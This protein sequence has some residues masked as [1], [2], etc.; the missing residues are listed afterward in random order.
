MLTQ[1][2][3]RHQQFGIGSLTKALDADVAC[4]VVNH[5]GGRNAL[6]RDVSA[7]DNKRLWLFVAISHH[8]NLHLCV[9][10]TL[11]SF[12]R[13]LIGH[14][15]PHEGFVVNHHDF[16]ACQDACTLGRTVLNDV[17][18]MDSVLADGEL[19]AHTRERSLQFLVGCLHVLGTDVY[20]MRVQTRKNLRHGILHKRVKIHLVHILIVDDVQQVVDSVGTRIDDVQSV[21]REMIGVERPHSDA[22]DATKGHQ[23]RHES[24]RLIWFHCH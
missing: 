24:I 18:Y 11:E 15:F 3:Q 8:A 5:V 4:A 1:L 19:D 16:V 20:A 7:G 6:Q 17:L 21:S 9:L 14:H 10:G 23:Q 22:D 2:H 12:H 13:F